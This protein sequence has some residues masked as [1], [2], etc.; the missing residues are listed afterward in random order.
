MSYDSAEVEDGNI[1]EKKIIYIC[2]SKYLFNDVE[3]D[4]VMLR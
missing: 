3:S 4:M 2:S 1:T